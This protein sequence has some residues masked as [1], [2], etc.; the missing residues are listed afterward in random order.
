MLA[1]WQPLSQAV[2]LALVPA[3]ASLAGWA[4]APDH[5]DN[6]HGLLLNAAEFADTRLEKLTLQTLRDFGI[7]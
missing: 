2:L 4:G 7:Y 1:R 5:P 3:Q 6:G